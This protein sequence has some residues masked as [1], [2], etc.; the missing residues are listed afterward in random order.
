MPWARIDDSMYDHPKTL[1]LLDERGGLAAVGLFTLLLSYCNRHLTDGAFTLVNA[2][3]CGGSA[4]MIGLLVAH[5]FVHQ[6]G[7]A[8]RI[9]DF[10]SYSKSREKVD[11][12]RDAW[13]ERQRRS[14]DGHG[15]VT[16]PSRRDTSES[17]GDV[18]PVSHSPVPVPVPSPV[19][20][21]PI[22][23]LPLR[24]SVRD[25]AA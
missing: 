20:G 7:D 14:R 3:R 25:D 1:A 11:A 10:L 16:P 13:K 21:P 22:G 12:E 18:T 2:R 4:S 24:G 6:E 8:Y 5:G 15:D 9:H 17:H 19:P 23:Y